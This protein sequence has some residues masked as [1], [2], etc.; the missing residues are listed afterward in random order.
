MSDHEEDEPLEPH[1]NEHD[2]RGSELEEPPERAVRN[3]SG[4]LELQVDPVTGDRWLRFCLAGGF[5]PYSQTAVALNQYM[6]TGG[7]GP[8]PE[9]P[10]LEEPT[11][12][13]DQDPKH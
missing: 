11:D 3:D 6:K 10:T 12:G 8:P 2:R 4:P 1:A 9:A 13:R 7:K 5:E